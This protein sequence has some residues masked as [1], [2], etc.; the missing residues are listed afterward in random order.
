[1]L[2]EIMPP[3]GEIKLG[4]MGSKICCIILHETLSKFNV[5][6]ILIQLRVFTENKSVT[7]PN[8]YGASS[9]KIQEKF[10][11]QFMKTGE[12]L[13]LFFYFTG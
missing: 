4:K 12:K 1:M 13:K 9:D 2:K 11:S 5:A 8:P 10:Y 3:G 6:T 7:R